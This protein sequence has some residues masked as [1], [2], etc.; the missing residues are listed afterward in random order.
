MGRVF[1]SLFLSIIIVVGFMLCF[2]W[3][4]DVVSLVVAI[5]FVMIYCT[6]TI[7]KRIEKVKN[8]IIAINNKEE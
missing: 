6:F 1:G 4:L 3:I 8:E 7:L 5:I 2:F